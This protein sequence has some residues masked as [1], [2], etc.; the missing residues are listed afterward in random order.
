[1]SLSKEFWDAKVCWKGGLKQKPRDKIEISEIVENDQKGTVVRYLLWGNPVAV[2]RKKQ[3]TL[4]VTDC[5]WKTVL[6]FN[7][8]NTILSKF[9][10][11]IYSSHNASYYIIDSKQG[12]VRY[13]WEGNHTIRLNAAMDG[14]VGI[15][16][17]TVSKANVACSLAL[18]KYYA[19]ALELMN[20]RKILVT[21]T[22]KGEVVC[23]CPNRYY[24]HKFCRPLLGLYVGVE[25]EEGMC[26]YFLRRVACSKVSSAFK[27]NDATALVETL[28]KQGTKF[29]GS[30]V[31]SLMS[32]FSVDTSLLPS[33]VL[34]Q[35]ALLK[36][37]E[38]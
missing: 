35:V 29:V 22:V 20:K 12:G 21:H 1:M 13:R 8:L 17:C 31:L 24:E 32:L 7:R 4:Q 14:L 25:A 37:V 3:N 28:F 15:C 18:Q 38:A 9:A 23:L 36:L 2:W 10:L 26:A 30:E 6:T 5:G 34:Q 19:S 16:P 27:N 33:K 11:S